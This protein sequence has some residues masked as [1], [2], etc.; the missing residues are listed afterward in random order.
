M[1]PTSTSAPFLGIEVPPSEVERALIKTWREAAQD[2]VAK[3]KKVDSVSEVSA[4]VKATLANLII[5]E[6]D[7]PAA[8]MSLDGLITELCLSFPSRFC[9]VRYR[10]T[11]PAGAEGGAA[12]KTGVSSRCVLA[13]SGAHVCSEELYIGTG[14]GSVQHVA[15]LVLSLL[16]PDTPVVLLMSCD[17]S[18]EQDP[19]F[20][21]LLR[22]LRHL[23]DRIIFD[24]RHIYNYGTAVTEFLSE[25]SDL[26]SRGSFG[27]SAG[28]GNLKTADLRDLTWARMS[29]WRSLVTE[30]FDGD[31]GAAPAKI[32]S[33]RIESDIPYADLA[34]GV[35]PVNALL[36]CGWFASKLGWKFITGRTDEKQSAAI[37]DAVSPDGAKIVVEIAAQPGGKGIRRIG[38]IEIGFDGTDGLARARIERNVASETVEVTATFAAADPSKTGTT[39]R[40]SP[41]ASISGVGALTNE[42][43]SGYGD[44]DYRAALEASR[45]IWNILVPDTQGGA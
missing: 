5:L 28:P 38:A 2:D 37:L 31:R 17:P 7:S 21:Q 30:L 11:Q 35:L 3:D 32:S 45:V 15:N 41:F 43:M 13:R 33:F 40:L 19:A 12:L 6:G 10:S 29:R 27:C 26:C 8:G 18:Q 20:H 16:V 44:P 39:K 4:R 9:I 22:S 24:S 23:S 14:P 34:S 36:L 42:L 25:T 1:N